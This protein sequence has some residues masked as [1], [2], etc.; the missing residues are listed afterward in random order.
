[1]TVLRRN[2]QTNHVWSYHDEL[3]FT[4]CERI[5]A[6]VRKL[7]WERHPLDH[8]AFLPTSD[9]RGTGRLPRKEGD[10]ERVVPRGRENQWFTCDHDNLNEF[11][12]NADWKAGAQNTACWYET[13][14]Y[15][16]KTFMTDWLEMDQAKTYA[17]HTKEAAYKA[18]STAFYSAVPRGVTERQAITFG[19]VLVPRPSFLFC[20]RPP[21]T[22]VKAGTRG[23]KPDRRKNGLDTA[24][25]EERA[26]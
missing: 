26:E 8:Q 21:S 4:G 10:P 22:S 18:G 14:K 7:G 11:G 19:W 6:S 25:A 24:S 9:V 16:T 23:P 12:I 17:R 3:E 1:M 20:P 2:R 15:G 5:E 13:M